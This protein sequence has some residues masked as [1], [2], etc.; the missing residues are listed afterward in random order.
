MLIKTLL[1]KVERFKSFVYGSV[2]VQLVDGLE[3]L[4][5]DSMHGAIAGR[6]LFAASGET[7]MIGIRSVYL[8]LCQSGHSRPTGRGM[9]SKAVAGCS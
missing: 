3:A 1:N 7:H 8:S 2:C 6:A 9:F 4:V 5:I